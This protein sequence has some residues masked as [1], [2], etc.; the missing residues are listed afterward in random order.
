MAAINSTT[1]SANNNQSSSSPI[2]TIQPLLPINV[3]SA[4]TVPTFANVIITSTL[5]SFTSPESDSLL[6][7]SVGAA[8]NAFYVSTFIF[9]GFCILCC[10]ISCVCWCCIRCRN[11]N[12]YNEFMSEPPRHT[13]SRPERGEEP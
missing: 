1:L 4:V 9:L 7:E 2:Q 12:R 13:E 8:A 5:D 10:V 6:R 11:N 3:S